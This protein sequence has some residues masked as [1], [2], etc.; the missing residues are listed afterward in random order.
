[1]AVDYS[2]IHRLLKILTLIQ[3]EKGWT[4]K[5]L[6]AECQTTERTIYRDMKMLEGAGIPY[7]YDE[8]SKGYGVRRDF[9]LP[10]V[11]LTLDESLALAVLAEHV[12]GAEQVPFTKAAARA[13]TKVRG[14]LPAALRSELDQIEQHVAVH[15]AASSA[16]KMPPTSTNLCAPPWPASWPCAANTS[17]FPTRRPPTTTVRSSSNP[18]PCSSTSAWYAIGHHSKWDE[19]RCMKLNRFT[20]IRLIDHPYE[21]P[22]DF[23]LKSHLGN[24]WHMIRGGK[25]HLVELRFD[26]AFAETIA[27]THWHA[28]QE[29]EWNEDES[30]TFRCRVDGLDEIVWWILGMGPHCQVKKPKELAERVRTLAAQVVEQYSGAKSKNLTKP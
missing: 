9:F 18:T 28:T 12:G 23:S 11:Q 26:P 1:M 22:R 29:I 8:E 10:P 5:R 15:L 30:I 16:P 7:F 21:I 27:D 6:A 17:R 3:G 2:R 20:S 25:T 14:Q 19:V 13:I 24:A 4:P